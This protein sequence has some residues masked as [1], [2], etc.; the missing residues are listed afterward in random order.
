MLDI[1]KFVE[2]QVW[3]CRKLAE[4]E[5]VTRVIK[6]DR[7]CVILK[8]ENGLGLVVPLTSSP[9]NICKLQSIYIEKDKESQLLFNQM[10]TV[11][12]HDLY[13]YIGTMDKELFEKTLQ[14]CVDYIT[15]KLHMVDGSYSYQFLSENSRDHYIDNEVIEEDEVI[16][17]DEKETIER[18][19]N[20]IGLE[21]YIR[22]APVS[23]I[24]KNFNIS[25]SFVRKHRSMVNLYYNDKVI[26]KI[27]LNKDFILT[28]YPAVIKTEFDIPAYLVNSYINIARGISVIESLVKSLNKR[29]IDYNT[30]VDDFKNEIKKPK[31]YIELDEENTIFIL[32]HSAMEVQDKYN[33]SENCY[34]YKNKVIEIEI[35]KPEADRYSSI[36]MSIDNKNFILTHSVRKI[37]LNFGINKEAAASYLQIVKGEYELLKN[38]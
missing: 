25:D 37:M 18:D 34:A 22:L 28:N 16:K 17:E 23:E 19:Q 12:V 7:P 3:W 9:N 5:D 8:A 33:I 2:G 30:I 35:A 27:V 4:D 20:L 29:E 1:N 10:T 36:E 26:D 21:E 6:K 31:N 32:E 38:K 14:L 13:R 24:S 15:L 11:S